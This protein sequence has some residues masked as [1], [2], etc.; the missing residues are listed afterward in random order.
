MQADVP[1][2][3]EQVGEAGEVVV[4][5]E[6]EVVDDHVDVGAG[7]PVAGGQL[8]GG[9]V[10]PGQA[11]A[12]RGDHVAEGVGG[13]ARRGGVG[14]EHRLVHTPQVGAAVVDEH[15]TGGVASE[16][17][18]AGHDGGQRGG[19]AR[20]LPA[21][22]HQVRAAHR[23][24]AQGAQAGAAD[25]QRDTRRGVELRQRH[26]GRQHPQARDGFLRG[27]GDD[28]RDVLVGAEREQH[29]SALGVEPAS[30]EAGELLLSLAVDE[31]VHRLAEFQFQPVADEVAD[32][33]TQHRPPR[34]GDDEVDPVRGSVGGQGGERVDEV[35][36]VGGERVPAVD[37]EER[38]TFLRAPDESG[39]LVD[40]APHPLRLG[41]P[42]DPGDVR[43]AVEGG[44][45][46]ATE[47][48]HVE[49][50]YRG[51]V[52]GGQ[53][54]HDGAQCRG[55]AGLGSPTHRHVPAGRP[56]VEHERVL[57]L[58]VGH[59]DDTD[60]RPERT[61]VLGDPRQFHHRWQR[62]QPHPVGPLAA[63]LGGGAGAVDD[64]VEKRRGFVDHHRRLR[65]L[66][67]LPP[68]EQGDAAGAAGQRGDVA[69]FQGSGDVGG[70]EAGEVGVVT[71]EPRAG[72]GRQMVGV[73]DAE[74]LPRLGRREGFQADPVG[75]VRVE[76]AQ[77]PLLEA[78]TGEQQ[79][80]VQGT[81][82]AADGDEEVREVGVRGE[83]LGELVDDDDQGGQRR[84]IPTG[85]AGGG[86]LGDVGEV[87]RL[88]QHLLPAVELAG[89][90]VEHALHQHGL[91]RQVGDH[92]RRVRQSLTAEERGTTLE[93]DEH[94]VEFVGAVGRRQGDDERAQQLRL[95]AARRTDAQP[96]RPHATVRGLLE[97]KAHGHALLRRADGHH[98][99]LPAEL[100][101]GP[102]RVRGERLDVGHPDEGQEVASALGG[103][104][105][106]PSVA[107]ERPR[108]QQRLL[109]SQAVG[110]PELLDAGRRVRH[111]I[112]VG[113][114][115][116][117]LL[118]RA[119]AQGGGRARADVDDGGPHGVVEVGL[120][121]GGRRVV[122]EE[123]PV[124][125][126]LRVTGMGQPLE[127]VPATA[128]RL[129]R[130]RLR[131]VRHHQLGDDRPRQ[132]PCPRPGQA[133]VAEGL[134]LHRDRHPG[135]G[136]HRLHRPAQAH[137]AHRIKI[138]GSPGVRDLDR[139]AQGGVPAADAHLEGVGVVWSAFPQST[140][141]DAGP[142]LPRLR[143]AV[144]LVGPLS[145]GVAQCLLPQGPEVAEVGPAR[146]VG[147]LALLRGE[148]HEQGH[149]HH[150]REQQHHR[151]GPRPAEHEERDHRHHARHHHQRHED[152]QQRHLPRPVRRRHR[153]RT[154]RPLRQRRCGLAFRGGQWLD[155]PAERAGHGQRHVCPPW[156]MSPAGHPNRRIS[157]V[158]LGHPPR[159]R[160]ART[161]G[162]QPGRGG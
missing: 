27:G 22:A 62:R 5:D 79:V 130:H 80:H 134:Q 146:L 147:V 122:D 43:Q 83:Q 58:V 160:T 145:F 45:L 121:A 32:R 7:P 149:S 63:G 16:C 71:Q 72:P 55:L 11:G 99:P 52:G 97:V 60:H 4:G 68:G 69:A 64:G 100:P 115:R 155:L 141:V 42:G 47:V 159:S 30:R 6:V 154:Q 90:G 124:T 21:D 12:E 13:G 118:L 136:A 78:L 51:R 9:D 103:G 127:P 14:G 142:Q 65:L 105:G 125:R 152:P 49:A 102:H 57:T 56:Q 132:I 29:R 158:M 77:P 26:P 117:S 61:D 89:D 48:E 109:R 40:D 156:Q 35:L 128:H 91:V 110:L 137:R 131:A 143:V 148:D 19:L 10:G 86:V 34:R 84:Q 33:R 150:E 94:E 2:V 101:A 120:G 138:L 114:Q 31:R 76:P 119:H 67:L 59:I 161:P 106:G 39:H 129:H 139:G 36:E 24:P 93:V 3:R 46:P 98:Q 144:E 112:P 82:Q 140:S 88:A 162:G 20:P 8:R 54:R 85:E 96:V 92:R 95:A 18:D 37:D 135:A 111:Q 66:E 123:D 133:Q 116:Q 28:V 74:D 108:Q 53:R 17:A 25:G 107:G 15:Q 23:V 153:L 126:L 104:P 151:V 44:Q 75:Q 70:L 38:V 157:P 113:A 81:P 87:A 73:G 1:G 41:A 50:Q